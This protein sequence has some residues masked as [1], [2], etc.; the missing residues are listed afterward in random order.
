MKREQKSQN[1]QDTQ[2]TQ[3]TQSSE[4]IQKNPRRK[5]KTEVKR[6]TKGGRERVRPGIGWFAREVLGKPLYPYQE[7]VGDAILRS[8]IEGRGDTFTVMFARQMGKNQLSAILEAYLL[9]AFEEG[10]I[11]KAA[12]TYKPQIINSRMRILT[13]LEAPLIR[14]RV[15]KSFGY[16]VGLAPEQAQVEAQSGPR[17][18]LFSA[19]PESSIVGA[20]ASLLLE[21]DEA[22]DVQIQKYDTELKPMAATQNATTVM[23]GTAWS[24]DTLLAQTRA[25]NLLREQE[26]GIKRHFE[27]DWQTLAD[28]NWRY[29]QFVEG[30]MLRLGADHLSI[31]T[32]YRLL[33]ISGAGCLLNDLQRHL[34]RGSH[35]W[36]AEPDE[37]ER[38]E[39][40]YY[41]AGLDVGGEERPGPGQEQRSTLH[42]KRDSTVLT[43]GRVHYNELDLPAI[44]IVHQYWWTGMKHSDQYAAVCT[45]VQQWNIHKLVIDATGL[46]EALA[47]LL[48]DRFASERISGYKFSRSSKSHLTYQVLSMI[49]SA[50]LK[51][52]SAESAPDDMFEECWKQLR[53]ARYR[54]PGEN[55][56]DMYVDA[57]EGHDDFLMSVALCAE[58]VREVTTRP[59]VESAIIRPRRLYEDSLEGRF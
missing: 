24:D 49:N 5:A 41:V 21:V 53:L 8:I 9:F 7:I 12:P 2:D 52:Y 29:K 55:L 14:A 10:T 1:S 3:D 15:W 22:Q 39:D 34:L 13:M 45:I 31:R 11:V 47:S 28:I 20:T 43:I 33:P 57:S 58:A 26:D 32:Q 6:G 35:H 51:L 17:L 37:E 36:Q 19:G 44:D 59:I 48:S 16:I 54:I 4:K 30:E 56:M 46:G 50:R 18:M 42:N 25:H 27:F 40:S 23:Y 38:S